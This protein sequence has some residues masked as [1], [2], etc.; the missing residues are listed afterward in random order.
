MTSQQ[1]RPISEI[2]TEVF[3][4]W[5][6]MSQHAKPY[7][8]AMLS[9]TYAT[10]MYGWDTGKEIIRYFLGNATSWRGDDARRIKAE[11]KLALKEAKA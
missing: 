5:R 10:D 2:A 3:R 1:V 7:A 9:L 4:T 8:E 6:P 11:L